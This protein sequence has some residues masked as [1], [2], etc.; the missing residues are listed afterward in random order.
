MFKFGRKD[1]SKSE[2]KKKERKD[3]KKEKKSKDSNFSSEVDSG[4]ERYTQLSYPP[5][6]APK[7]RTSHT[8]SASV[9][10]KKDS[11]KPT[12]RGILKIRSSTKN[13]NATPEPPVNTNIDDPQILLQNTRLNEEFS[14]RSSP[15]SKASHIIDRKKRESI[16]SITMNIAPPSAPPPATATEKVYSVNLE[17]PAVTPL[18]TSQSRDLVIARQPRGDFGFNLRWAPYKDSSSDLTRQVVYAEPGSSGD[19]SGIVAGDRIIEIN[20]KNVE[21]SRRDEV[22]DLIQKSSNPLLLKVQQISEISEFSL[23]SSVPVVRGAG[24]VGQAESVVSIRE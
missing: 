22:I 24:S 9:N 11:S 6:V 4:H 19:K 16:H 12:G 1:K 15:D 2:D 7:P 3:S 14:W 10:L 23:R 8:S 5:P 21:S 18:P 17:L 20:G 13:K